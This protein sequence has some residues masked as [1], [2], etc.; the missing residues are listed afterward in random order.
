MS[1]LLFDTNTFLRYLT[2][3]VPTQAQRITKR[4]REAEAGKFKI[5]VLNTTVVE[6]LYQLEHWYDLIKTDAVQKM[7]LLLSP[8]WIDVG[9][10]ADVLEAL[11]LYSTRQIDFVDLLTWTIAKSNGYKIASFDRDF[12]KL[13]PKLRIEP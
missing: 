6:V 1:T 5:R 9:H 7:I 4:F 11:T 12:D 13:T 10:K 8:K 2:K 3:D